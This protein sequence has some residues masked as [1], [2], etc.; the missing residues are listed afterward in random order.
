M[1]DL[2][3]SSQFNIANSVTM[4]PLYPSQL[5]SRP[6][7]RGRVCKWKFWPFFCPFVCPS[8]IISYSFPYS[9]SKLT[10][11]PP[12]DLSHATSPTVSN[13]PHPCL[14]CP[15]VN[16]SPFPVNWSPNEQ[17]HITDLSFP[18]GVELCV[19]LTFFDNGIQNHC[20]WG[21]QWDN[22]QESDLECL[23]IIMKIRKNCH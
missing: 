20:Y 8:V 1:G 12:V 9:N 6:Q 7:Y 19:N 4:Y 3:S 18:L 2:A 11:P 23:L 14:P 15:P 5:F 16:W 22:R 17:D 10:Q 13:V 21:I